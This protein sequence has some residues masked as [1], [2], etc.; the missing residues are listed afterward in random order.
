VPLRWQEAALPLSLILFLVVLKYLPATAHLPLSRAAGIVAFGYAAFLALRLIQ[1]E[2]AVVLEPGWSALRPSAVEYFA[3]YGAGALSA[4]LMSAIILNGSRALD[5][6][7][8][9]AAFIAAVLLAIG[10]GAIAMT[11]VF[12]RIRW[13]AQRVEHRSAFGRVTAVAWSEVV[14]CE[15]SWR[16]VRIRTPDRRSVVFSQFQSG[17]AELALLASNRARRNRETA[18]RAYASS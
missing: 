15:P 3:C 17:A 5:M 18:S 7:E 14:A 10:A 16:G 1:S 13:N 6:T 9:F 8:L 12:A 4:V 2:S 11:S